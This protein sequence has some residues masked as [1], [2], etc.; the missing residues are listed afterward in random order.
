LLSGD[1]KVALID[2]RNLTFKQL[3]K[4]HKNGKQNYCYTIKE[5]G[6]IGMAKINHPRKTKENA[7]VIKIT[8]DNNEEIIC[9][10]DHKFMRRDYSY[11]SAEK[12]SD[13][14]SL[15]P[16]NKRLSKFDGKTAIQGYEMVFC[17]NT[18]RWIFTHQLSEGYPLEKSLYST[19]ME[20]VASYNHKIKMITKLE[21]KID[22]YDLEVEGT[23][24]FALASGVFVHNSAKQARKREFQAVLPLRG[25]ILNV[26]KQ[27]WLKS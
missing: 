3:V 24:N 18:Q 26:E 10:P 21:H 5:D 4:E 1:T 25:K 15:M 2:G 19:K 23:H 11:I 20:S 8:L 14:M 17:P 7:D 6:S 27:G 12:L 16:L 22:V 13:S 9:T